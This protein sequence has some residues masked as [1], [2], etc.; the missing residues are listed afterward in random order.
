MTGSSNSKPEARTCSRRQFLA[1]TAGATALTTTSGFPATATA[2]MS[3]TANSIRQLSADGKPPYGHARISSE[4]YRALAEAERFQQQNGN[5]LQFSKKVDAVKDLGLDPNGNE[6]I[7]PVLNSKIESGMLV[8]M[9][10]GTYRAKNEIRPGVEGKY[11][12]VGKGYQKS[13]QP[14]KPGKNSVVIKVESDGPITLFNIG[15]LDGGFFGNFVID[16]RAPR[17]HGG[18]KIRSSGNVRVR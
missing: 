6:P 17:S 11:G 16:Q 1:G 14:P 9:P 2:D 18:V 3:D 15:P 4:G 13:K 8:V 5:P 7:D 12:I 10:P